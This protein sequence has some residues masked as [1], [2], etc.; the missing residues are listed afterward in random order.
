GKASYARAMIEL[1]VDV[2]L[3]DTIVV[4]VSK[5][6][7]EGFITSIVEYEWTHPICLECKVFGH[8]QDDCPKE[9]VSTLV[10]EE[11]GGGHQTPTNSTLVV[12]R[13]IEIE[14]KMLDG[15]LVLVDEHGKLLEMEVTSEA[16]ASKPSTSMGDQL[17]EFN[18]DEV[19][20]HDDETFRYMPSISGGG[21]CEDDLNFYDGYEAQVYDLPKQMQTFMINLIYAFIDVLGSNFP[22]LYFIH[23][24]GMSFL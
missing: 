14:R 4:V 6:C 5:F 10:D 11:E 22:S 19:E 21:F 9:T 18:K 24:I 8:V 12:A 16:S 17:V 23:K 20:L 13:T 7:G 2:E 3:R 1:K 15:K